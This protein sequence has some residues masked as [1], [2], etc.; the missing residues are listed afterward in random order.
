MGWGTWVL[1][2]VGP[3]ARQIMISLGVSLVSYLGV[4]VAVNSMLSQAKA[5]YA[6]SQSADVANMVAMS[7]VNTALSIIAGAIIGRLSMLAIK[8][9]Q[10]T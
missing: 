4:S 7:G 1:A 5:A 10:A 9:F 3:A 2:L 6:A 8:R